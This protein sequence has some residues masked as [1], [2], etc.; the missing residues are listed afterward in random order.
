MTRF[1]GRKK[2]IKVLLNSFSDKKGTL[3]TIKGRRRIGK[4]TL[5]KELAKRNKKITL[6]Y[7]TSLPPKSGTTDVQER[8]AYA[9]Q[10]KTEFNLA[11]TPPHESWQELFYFIISQ[12]VAPYTIL[13][14]DEVN[15]LA[16]KSNVSLEQIL[17]EVWERECA[18]KSNFMMILSGSLASWMQ[19]NIIANEGFVGRITVNMTLRELSLGNVR[20]FFGKRS[21][22]S[23]RDLM[24][25]LCATGC[26][27]LY[28]EYIDPKQDAETNLLNI[29]YEPTGALNDEFNR[30]FS[31]LFSP[32][33]KTYRR[34]LEALGTSK[35]ALTITQISDTMGSHYT[36]R[37]NKAVK[38]LTD[39]GF[40]K[41]VSAW[42]T[43][44]CKQQ[45]RN[46]RYKIAD[47]YT[48]FFFRSISKQNEI[49][50][51]N[52]QEG[53][54]VN[55]AS[56]LGLQFENLVENNVSY[57]LNELDVR[58]PVFVGSY[59]QIQTTRQQGCQIDLLIQTKRRIYVCECKLKDDK[60]PK[61]IISEVEQKV[62]RLAKPQNMVVCPV[63]IHLNGVQDSV[64][65]ED[66][67][68]RIIDMSDALMA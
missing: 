3:N 35:S 12:C 31:E 45:S 13:A 53:I 26:V 62:R 9:A 68:H 56:I 57:I 10:V 38:D 32:D 24:K 25:L 29:A 19:E 59:F 66:Y 65:Q 17:F 41:K 27:P 61:A 34:V 14:I 16:R 15:W 39:T 50:R 42:N 51:L 2:E 47:N 40:I 58:N 64:E 49:A 52:K 33:N 21:K 30:M 8:E 28:L 54:P 63:L 55:L 36:G 5:I 44:T 4:S 11:Y 37:M 7:L 43:K 67:F 6:R 18:L 1:V 23:N 20:E 60:L 46:S 22:L 48:A